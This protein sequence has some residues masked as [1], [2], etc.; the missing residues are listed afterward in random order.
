MQSFSSFLL[1]SLFF[2]PEFLLMNPSFCFSIDRGGTFT[3]IV[4]STP[5]GYRTLKLLSEN[6]QR[7]A[8]APREGIRRILEAS[9][10]RKIPP[11]LPLDETPIH[12]I[13]MG[14]TLATNA[15]L[16]RQGEPHLLLITQGFRDALA[17][18]TQNR[19]HL[20]DLKIT[21]PR[22]LPQ[23]ILE[24]QERVLWISD[25]HHSAKELVYGV[26]GTPYY[27]EMPLNESSTRL[28]LEKAY[29]K[30][31]RNLAITLLHGYDFQ[32][33]EKRIAQIAQEIGFTSIHLSCETAPYI[34]LI[35][36]AETTCVDAY[37]SPKIQEY[38]QQFR[39]G[40]LNQLQ[41]TPLWLMQSNGG[42]IPAPDF[43]G[44][45]AVL[46]GPAGGVVGYSQSIP[47]SHPL[48]GFDMGG[49]STDVSR[50]EKHYDIQSE[51]EI[52]GIRL[53]LPQLHIRTVAAG[54]GSRLSFHDGRFCVGPESVGAHPGPV[55]YGKGG[56]L[57]LTDA[58]LLL[59]RISAKHFPPVFGSEENQTLN[60]LE[61]QKA[62][63]LL[64]QEINLKVSSLYTPEDL[65]EAFIQVANELMARP[66]RE[67]SSARGYSLK[68][69]HLVCF[70][71][72]SAQHA[73]ALAKKLEISTV[74]IHPHSSVLSALG[75]SLAD[76]VR[77]QSIPLY[78]TPLTPEIFPQLLSISKTSKL[79]SKNTYPKTLSTK[80]T[81]NAIS[82]SALKELPRP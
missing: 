27:I 57:A 81:T 70:G 15:L 63:K 78:A 64:T 6:P 37:L 30:G 14:T 20:F 80:S 56:A 19:P 5:Q 35:P 46:S 65:A 16:E 34:K 69:H 45:R 8:D 62:F 49:T 48:I 52:E 61:T 13:R 12:W 76:F 43:L 44:S 7:Y 73:C 25:P 47:S 58:N 29:Q 41:N 75:I 38:L 39:S 71:G 31:W 66:I 2:Y 74:W 50:F 42:L 59:G 55:C 21:R 1:S 77:E 17:I 9:L 40:F 11:D 79:N 36:R 10:L 72:A 53:H 67:I 23:Q 4:A 18:G 32:N 82:T 60:L 3:D 22:P 26:S 28:A 24:I 68:E 51:N 54:G 33:H